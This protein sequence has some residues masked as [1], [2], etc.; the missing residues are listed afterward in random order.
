[1]GNKPQEISHFYQNITNWIKDTKAHEITKM[2]VL[3]ERAKAYLVAA[4]SI[5]EE[6]IKQ[7]IDSFVYDLR[8]FYQQNQAQAQSS[9]YLGLMNE[10]LWQLLASMTDKSQ[11]EWSELMDDFQHDG[12]YY[13]GDYIGFGELE[14]Q[15]CHQS[16]TITHLSKVSACIHCDGTQFIRHALNP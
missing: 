9:L 15:S 2:V 5:P 13:L 10:N 16:L 3:V 11:V 1:M 7:F 6:N 8:E 14:C 12:I 4:E